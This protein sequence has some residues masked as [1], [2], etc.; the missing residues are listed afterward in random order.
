VLFGDV[1]LRSGDDA[2]RLAALGMNL[3]RKGRHMAFAQPCSCFAGKLCGIYA[4]RPKRCRTFECRLLQRTQADEVTITEAM[5]AIK[6]ARKQ[7]ETVRQ[8]VR[9]LGHT[10][11]RVPLNRRYAE[12]MEQ[13]ID[14]AAGDQNQKLRGQLMRAVEKLSKILERDFLT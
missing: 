7:V 11:E 2:E 1:E 8:L 4:D 6:A 13:P 14:L 3:F 10:D 12:V 9:K 5:K